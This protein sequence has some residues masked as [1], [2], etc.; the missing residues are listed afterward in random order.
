VSKHDQFPAVYA[1]L[2]AILAPYADRLVTTVDAADHYY[3]NAPKP[4]PQRPHEPLFFGA[5]RIRKN[6]V[7]YYLMP[8]YIQ[9]ALLEGLSAPLRRRMQGKS[10]FNFTAVDEALFDELAALT[11]RGFALYAQNEWV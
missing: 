4:H 9:P 6:Y 2:K 7:S 11:A 10:C 1:R 5:V 8:V 3:L